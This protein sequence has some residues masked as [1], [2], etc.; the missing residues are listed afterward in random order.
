MDRVDHR[1]H[2][3]IGGTGD[4]QHRAAQVL[5][6]VGVKVKLQGRCPSLQIR[7]N[8]QNEVALLFQCLVFGDDPVQNIVIPILCQQVCHLALEKGKRVLVV[9]IQIKMRQ[10]QIDVLVPFLR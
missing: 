8:A 7:A 4:H 9:E 1:G 3:A 10:K 6:H 5:G 2:V